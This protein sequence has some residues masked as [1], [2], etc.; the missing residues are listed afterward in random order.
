M[1]L[2]VSATGSKVN[3]RRVFFASA[4]ARA[5]TIRNLDGPLGSGDGGED[6]V[7]QFGGEIVPQGEVA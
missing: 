6:V 2:V 7:D 1:A 5:P 4:A 3:C